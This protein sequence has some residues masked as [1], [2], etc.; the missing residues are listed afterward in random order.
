MAIIWNN[1][2]MSQITGH[3]NE[4]VTTSCHFLSPTSLPFVTIFVFKSAFWGKYTSTRFTRLF[5]LGEN[6]KGT[7]RCPRLL[8]KF[9]ISALSRDFPFTPPPRGSLDLLT[10]LNF[11]LLSWE[12]GFV[13]LFLWMEFCDK[14]HLFPFN[15]WVLLN[16]PRLAIGKS[17]DSYFVTHSLYSIFQC[18]FWNVLIKIDHIY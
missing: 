1:S 17:V 6:K 16:F 14:K 9:N 5:A 15:R 10:L 11:P 4:L 18:C 8:I 7:W 13:H 2:S 3:R 12:V